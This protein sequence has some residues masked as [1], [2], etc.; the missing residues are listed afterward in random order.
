[1]LLLGGSASP[2]WL[3][4]A[5]DVL[6]KTIPHV[7]RIEFP[8]FNHGASSDLSATNRDSHPQE[9]AQAMRRF[10]ADK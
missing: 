8:G 3:K 5:L 10:L 1:M 4:Q 9:I 6:E 2:T 7:Q